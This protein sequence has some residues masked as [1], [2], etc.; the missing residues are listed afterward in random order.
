MAQAIILA[1]GKGTR[2]KPYTNVF[3][4]PLVP[5]GD[6]PILEIIIRLL[7][8]AD[9]KDIVI[10]T[11]HLAELIES[12]F[13][14]GS[15]WGVKI[16]YF[17]EKTPLS[18]AGALAFLEHLDEDFLV[19][20]GD[21]LTTLDFARLL[22]EHKKSKAAATLS[23]FKRDNHIDFGVIK[24]DAQGNLSDYIEKPTDH[25]WVSMGVNALNKRALKAIKKG[26]ALGMPDLLMRLK[27][28]GERVRCYEFSDYWL[29]IGRVDDYERAQKEF[30]A[31]RK[32]FLEG[33]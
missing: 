21:I 9:I 18:T 28:S 33:A 11:G 10:I 12:Y 22:D 5:I 1:G 30:E 6:T 2:L 17:R 24:K 15:K 13:K 31:R 16:T 3:P 27:A 14:D 4:K 19:L 25:Y 20:N 26:E 23:I 32:K 29:D 7:A 8:R